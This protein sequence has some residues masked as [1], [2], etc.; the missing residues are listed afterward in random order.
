MDMKNCDFA[1]IAKNTY[2]L[3]NSQCARMTES[4]GLL[5]EKVT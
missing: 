1:R 3:S 2:K 4:S 5:E